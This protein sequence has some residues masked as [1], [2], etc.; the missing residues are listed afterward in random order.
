LTVKPWDKEFYK[1][2]NSAIVFTCQL[3]LSEADLQNDGADV[4]YTIQWIDV[5]NNREIT[6]KTGRLVFFCS[7]WYI[8]L[9]GK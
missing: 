7:C 2:L 6:L 1:S 5:R 9:V 4:E 8:K 3:E